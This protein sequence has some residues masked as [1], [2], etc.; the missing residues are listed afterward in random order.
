MESQKNLSKKHSRTP[1]K[2]G[3]RIPKKERCEDGLFTKPDLR[4]GK[5]KFKQN[6][7]QL[8]DYGKYEEIEDLF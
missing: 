4:I 7:K 3:R 6:M 2:G 5:V 8:I 1:P